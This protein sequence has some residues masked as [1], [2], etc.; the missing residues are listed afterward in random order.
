MK[1]SYKKLWVLLAER[2]MSKAELREELQIATGTMTK[3]NKNQ[4]VSLSVL[5]RIC[6]YFDCNIGDICDAVRTHS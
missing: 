4:E 3:L 2:E 1:V 5:L 6:D